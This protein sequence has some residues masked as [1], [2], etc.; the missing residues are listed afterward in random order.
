[1]DERTGVKVCGC[2]LRMTDRTVL[3]QASIPVGPPLIDPAR[4]FAEPSPTSFVVLDRDAFCQEFERVVLGADRR[5]VE[6]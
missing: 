3:L 5:A 2:A 1:M 6:R 4:V